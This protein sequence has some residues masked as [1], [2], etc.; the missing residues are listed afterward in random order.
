M[1]VVRPGTVQA[2]RASS[3]RSFPRDG[4]PRGALSFAV[5][6]GA[7]GA[8]SAGRSIWGRGAGC[9]PGGIPQRRVTVFEPWRTDRSDLAPRASVIATAEDPFTAWDHS[10]WPCA[11][12]PDLNG[13]LAAARG[14]TQQ[15][16]G[17]LPVR[18]LC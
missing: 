13:A 15:V 16:F 8:V 4:R 12:D 2:R 6:V 10:P 11:E 14:D 17:S 1:L 5:S 9:L 3:A 18:V 7:G